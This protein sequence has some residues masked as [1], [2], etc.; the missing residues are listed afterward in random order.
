MEVAPKVTVDMNERLIKPAC[1]ERADKFVPTCSS[2][3]DG[4]TKGPKRYG[5][6]RW[7]VYSEGLSTLLRKGEEDKSV[8]GVK[9]CRNGPSVIHL[10]FEDDTLLFVEASRHGVANVRRVLETYGKASATNPWIPK[11]NG[12]KPTMVADFAKAFKVSHFIDDSSR[13]WNGK[14]V[15]EVFNPQ[16][17]ELIMGIPISRFE[18]KDTAA[19][20]FTRNGIYT[21]KS[22]YETALALRRNGQMGN[23]IVGEGSNRESRRDMWKSVWA[24]PC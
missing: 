1:L 7:G 5:Q 14:L 17:A 13:K 3:G 2:S 6:P 8:K 4:T 18:R 12:F 21:V 11:D 15:Q 20:H 23:G 10:F 16:E 19:W 24:L 9:I 22:G